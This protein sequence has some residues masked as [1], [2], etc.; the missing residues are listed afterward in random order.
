MHYYSYSPPYLLQQDNRVTDHRLKVNFELTSFLSGDIESAVQVCLVVLVFES[1]VV[2][3]SKSFFKKFTVLF[4]L[5][6]NTIL[7][8]LLIILKR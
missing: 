1:V 7:L 2:I 5:L 6:A 8:F 4:Y 3:V